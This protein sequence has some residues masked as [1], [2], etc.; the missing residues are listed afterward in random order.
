MFQWCKTSF[1]S[2]AVFS[3]LMAPMAHAQDTIISH[4]ISSYGDL[5]Y[6]ADYKHFDYVN[7]NAPQGGTL[8][9]LPKYGGATF[10]SF[11][12]FILKGANVTALGNMYASLLTGSLDEPDSAYVYLAE[13][14]EYPEDRSWVV[15]KMRRDGRFHDGMPI[16][17]HDVVFSY[18]I[19]LEK[20]HPFYKNVAFKDYHSVEALDDYTVKFTFK[21][22]ANT[23]DLP[24]SAGG[25]SILPKH[26]WQDR[27]FAESSLDIPVGSGEYTI[28]NFEA[29]QFVEYC[30]VDDYWGK[31][32][33]ANVGTG[34]F[35]CY[36]YEYF[37]D[38]DVAFEAFKAGD[39]LFREENTSKKWKT[40]YDF[41]AVEKGWVKQTLAPDA[42]PASSQGI[43]INLR[44][45]QFQNVKTREALQYLF[46]FEWTNKTVFYDS[47]SRSDSF[48]ENSDME[49]S[50]MITPEELALLEP[51]RDSLPAAVFD[52]PVF[53]P[54]VMKTQKFDRSALRKANKLLAEAGWVLDGGLL[55][56]AAGETLSIEFI[57]DSDDFLHILT[58]IIDTMKRAGI[59]AKF[60][61]IDR[62][63]MIERRKS[64]D[65]DMLVVGYR[66]SLSPGEEIAQQYGSVSITQQDSANIA[67]YGSPAVDALIKQVGSAKSRAEM[68]VAVRA[69]DRILRA[70]H[71]RVPNW[72]LPADRLAYWDV[73]GRP[74][75]QPKYDNGVISTWW[76]DQEKLDALKAQG[77]LK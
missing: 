9:M 73:F 56:N 26:Y 24:I 74:D 30:K 62:P 63:Q 36:R 45:P 49:A 3:V 68:R 60:T 76:M 53:V 65:F 72:Y 75:V 39:Y 14:I 71:I 19:L 40:Q 12:Q 58:P 11:N 23:R 64:Y 35:D 51:Y 52:E 55:K 57:D 15:F 31:D 77:A 7:P 28:A 50:G 47:Y 46:N 13:S 54:P 59:D 16:T 1:K 5:K 67:G 61:Q 48:W 38:G 43:W 41:P 32:L 42:T 2:V 17:A 8:T 37:R 66:T 29:G 70:E 22:G 34:N 69:I 4:G 10:D 27:D 20:G 44:R 25:L 33:P 18:D 6:P 21:E